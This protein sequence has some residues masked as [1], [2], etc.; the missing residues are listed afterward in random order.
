MAE[1]KLDA[2][3]LKEGIDVAL[4]ELI[5]YDRRKYSMGS[6]DIL[7]EQRYCLDQILRLFEQYCRDNDICQV[8]EGYDSHEPNFNSILREV[9]LTE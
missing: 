8:I 1:N 5:V 2:K 9:K 6:I 4:T 7:R 3:G